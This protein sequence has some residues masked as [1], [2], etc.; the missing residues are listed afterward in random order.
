MSIVY[1]ELLTP[2][3]QYGN[4]MYYNAL[5]AVRGQGLL[6][7]RLSYSIFLKVKKC[8]RWHDE[9]SKFKESY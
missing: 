3:S 8:N 6:A 7:E 4:Q 5:Y 1:S 9:Y 2:S